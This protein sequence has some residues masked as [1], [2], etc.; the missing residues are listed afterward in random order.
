MAERP[1]L[2][3]RTLAEITAGATDREQIGDSVG[4]SG[5]RIERLRI[6]GV[7]LVLKYLDRTVDWTLRAIDDD[8]TV[9]CEMWSRGILHQ[10]PLCL[11]QP[12]IAVGRDRGDDG[13][14]FTTLLMEDIGPW[15]I[16]A[17][18][19]LLTS[20][21]HERIL[22]HMA[23]M[24]ATFW[25]TDRPIDLVSMATRYRELSPW[26][27]RDEAVLGSNSLVPRL[28][29]EGWE[30]LG[31]VAPRAS[32]VLLPLAEDPTPLIAAFGGT[33]RTLLHGNWKL[34]NLGIDDDGRT[35]V[36][37]WEMPG[38]G[39]ALTDLAWYLAIN[40]RRLAASKEA[41]IACYKEALERRGVDTEGWWSRQLALAL[42]GGGVQFGWEKCLGGYDDELAWWED[43]ALAAAALLE[44]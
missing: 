9:L 44:A 32:A 17:T 2:A 16:P 33:P 34:D 12:I 24:H 20:E 27:A 41:T 30:Q 42:L 13:S 23:A 29:G 14:L 15:L 26:T 25:E 43:R 8:G 21:E 40:C 4:K 28:V 10:L 39:P 18:D 31:T 22:D 6:D 5:A 35:I 1:N 11:R 7:P 19:V 36:L 37:D 3:I 38:R